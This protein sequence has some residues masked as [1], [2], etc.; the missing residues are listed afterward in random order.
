MQSFL[1]GGQSHGQGDYLPQH[2]DCMT[3]EIGMIHADKHSSVSGA[4]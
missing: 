1:T 2:A 4:L 3:A